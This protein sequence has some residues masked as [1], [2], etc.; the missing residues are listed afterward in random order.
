MSCDPAEGRVHVACT[1]SSASSTLVE[2]KLQPSQL[3]I[4]STGPNLHPNLAG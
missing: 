2:E 3:G 4:L 1:H